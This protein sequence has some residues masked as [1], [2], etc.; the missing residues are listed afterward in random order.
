M[1]T[2]VLKATD[3]PVAQFVKVSRLGVAM[4]G[5][6]V[7][8]C[9]HLHTK[10]GPVAHFSQNIAK[11]GVSCY[12]ITPMLTSDLMHDVQEGQ[13]NCQ[14]KMHTGTHEVCPYLATTS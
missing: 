10:M 4:V 13:G 3:L 11:G 1:V 8:A 6:V 14:G 5:H 12:N 9:F 2:K 7:I